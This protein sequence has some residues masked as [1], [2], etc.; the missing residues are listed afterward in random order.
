[1][2]LNI[3]NIA[4]SCEYRY[5][6]EQLKNLISYLDKLIVTSTN[7]YFTLRLKREVKLLEEYFVNFAFVEEKNM[8]DND[9]LICSSASSHIFSNNTSKIILNDSSRG[10][11]SIIYDRNNKK[12][13]V[14]EILIKSKSLF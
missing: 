14:E 8:E 2:I 9:Y 4:N 3:R 11:G 13:K 10:I 6:A 5:I 1:M 12:E 7:D